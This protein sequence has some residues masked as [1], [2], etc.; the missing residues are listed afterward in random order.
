MNVVA[1]VVVEVVVGSYIAVVDIVAV[2]CREMTFVVTSFLGRFVCRF[3]HILMLSVY[4]LVFLLV[5]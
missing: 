3:S 1:A 2:E 5:P 4:F